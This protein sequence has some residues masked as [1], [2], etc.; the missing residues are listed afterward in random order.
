[1]INELEM[2]IVDLLQGYLTYDNTPVQVVKQFSQHPTRPV[3]TL[4][5][6]S[7][8]T[9][10]VYID[11][12]QAEKYYEYKAIININLWCDTEQQ[13]A[14]LTEQIMDCFYKEQSN[15]YRYC[16]Q[17]TNGNCKTLQNTCPAVNGA[18]HTCKNPERY[19]FETLQSRHALI[20]GTVIIDPPFELDDLTDHP[21]LLRSIF[22]CEGQ[23]SHTLG[24]VVPLRSVTQG[25]VD[26]DV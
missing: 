16:P 3:I 8:T 23:Y 24:G 11:P 17:Y 2:Y 4:D 13:R 19:G 21:P 12:S 14:D 25:D 10:A 9:Q 18:H 26:L 15:H 20:K 5:I 22:R 7:I 1:M 6:Q